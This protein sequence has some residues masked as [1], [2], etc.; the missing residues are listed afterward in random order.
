MAVTVRQQP[1]IAM[2]SPMVTPCA[3]APASSRNRAC[4]PCSSQRPIFPVPS[5]KPVNIHPRKPRPKDCRELMLCY[6]MCCTIF[7][8]LAAK[9]TLQ[10]N[11]FITL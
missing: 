11:I 3:S 6:E 5:T 7:G 1:L 9:F 4:P 2:L 10:V 8:K